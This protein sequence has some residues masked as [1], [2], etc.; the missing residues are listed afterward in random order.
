MFYVINL[1]LILGTLVPSRWE[2]L[3]D[4]H[5]RIICCLCVVFTKNMHLHC[6]S[7]ICGFRPQYEFVQSFYMFIVVILV[8]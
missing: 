7:C 6:S 1:S 3:I 5:S 4:I 2:L 8:M